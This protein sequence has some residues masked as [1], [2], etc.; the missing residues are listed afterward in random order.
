MYSMRTV[1]PVGGIHTHDPV[2][3]WPSWHNFEINM[4]KYAVV[5]NFQTPKKS[6]FQKS[7]KLF[8]LLIF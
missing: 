1:K 8:S 7:L 6:Q 4:L 3:F 2:F 5:A